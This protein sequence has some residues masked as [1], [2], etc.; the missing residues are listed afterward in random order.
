MKRKSQ[1]TIQLPTNIV[2]GKPVIS[3]NCGLYL[4][5]TESMAPTLLLYFADAKYY[6]AQSSFLDHFLFESLVA[7]VQA[8][9]NRRIAFVGCK[10]EFAWWP[11]TAKFAAEI[12]ARYLV[13]A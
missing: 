6:N 3:Q 13:P 8:N 1:N 11:K 5:D 2:N 12:R 9:P 10:P 7:I 4:V